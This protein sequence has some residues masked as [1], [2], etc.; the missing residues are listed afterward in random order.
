[1][2]ARELLP[3]LRV[4]AKSR[5]GLHSVNKVLHAREIHCSAEPRNVGARLEFV[6]VGCRA[7]TVMTW[8]ACEVHAGPQAGIACK[9]QGTSPEAHD[10]ASTYSM[11]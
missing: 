9:K 6:H 8:H 1:L 3:R 2:V 4:A 7:I 5:L 10:T 11:S